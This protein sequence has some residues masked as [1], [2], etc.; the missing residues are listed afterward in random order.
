MHPLL[1]LGLAHRR[2]DVSG[3]CQQ[4]G[5]AGSGTGSQEARRGR[6]RGKPR[7][8]P[9][10][11]R[12]GIHRAAQQLPQARQRHLALGTGGSSLSLHRLQAGHRLHQ[13]ALGRDAFLDAPAHLL[14]QPLVGGQAS[15]QRLGL[16]LR[17]PPVTI[18]LQHAQ[19]Q[20]QAG[21]FQRSLV[22]GQ[23]SLGLVGARAQPPAAPQRLLQAQRGHQPVALV[24]PV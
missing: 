17:A 18:G 10:G 2:V 22:G 11:Q 23:R 3:L 16:G 20:L 9:S 6:C 8:Q 13:V 15:G 7:R 14:A 1:G 19:A 5:R 4:G 21:V 24:Q 12:C